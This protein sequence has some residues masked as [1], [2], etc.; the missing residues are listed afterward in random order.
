MWTL[1]KQFLTLFYS[2]SLWITYCL[3]S[4]FLCHSLL[5]YV[6]K[7]KKTTWFEWLTQKKMLQYFK[8]FFFF[9][10]IF[11]FFF[12][13]LGT[14]LSKNK[15]IVSIKGTIRENC[16]WFTQRIKI[17]NGEK[18]EHICKIKFTNTQLKKMRNLIQ[19]SFIFSIKKNK[20]CQKKKKSSP[21]RNY[22]IL[23]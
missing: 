16:R 10:V 15:R 23:F 19:I 6:S 17:T 18:Y 3:L 9:L 21:L 11:K 1:W 4:F 12:I 20:Y 22:F 2:W 7:K 14:S 5:V 8:C 13:F